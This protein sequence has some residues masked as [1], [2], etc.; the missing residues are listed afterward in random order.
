M[1]K[2]RIASQLQLWL[3]AGGPLGALIIHEFGVAPERY[4]RWATAA[5]AIVPSLFAAAWNWWQNREAAQIKATA[6]LPGVSK[7]V[8]TDTVNGAVGSMARSGDHPSVVTETQNRRD[9][10]AGEGAGK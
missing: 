1:N 3:A 8:V 2:A 7:V 10:M 5:I 9:V 4:D 6:E